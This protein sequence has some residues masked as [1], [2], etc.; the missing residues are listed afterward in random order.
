MLRVK[1]L[2]IHRSFIPHIEA[3][4]IWLDF[5]LNGCVPCETYFY[6]PD[7]F[8]KAIPRIDGL[9]GFDAHYQRSYGY[10]RT[11]LNT[12]LLPDDYA[13]DIF[14]LGLR[15]D[16]RDLAIPKD[17]WNKFHMI[18]TWA[19]SNHEANKYLKELSDNPV[20]YDGGSNQEDDE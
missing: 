1:P 5:K 18:P 20:L 17:Q 7:G 19:Y 3:R 6:Q 13:E 11:L 9:E 12:Y 15:L 14:R 10:L 2:E 8:Q 16:K 4:G